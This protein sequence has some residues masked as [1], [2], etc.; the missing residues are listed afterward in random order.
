MGVSLV[1]LNDIRNVP[2]S[3]PKVF[4]ALLIQEISDSDVSITT[5]LN[6]LFS[7]ATSLFIT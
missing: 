5:D 4:A 6:I 2:S 1:V 3:N 7:G